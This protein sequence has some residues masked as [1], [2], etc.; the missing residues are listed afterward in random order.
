LNIFFL[1]HLKSLQLLDVHIIE[2][3]KKDVLY[4]HMCLRQ[5][6]SRVI[7]SL[8]IPVSVHSNYFS[9]Q[10]LNYSL[11]SVF[12]GF[13]FQA[14]VYNIIIILFGRMLPFF[15]N[16][17]F[18]G[19]IYIYSIATILLLLYEYDDADIMNTIRTI[20]VTN[21]NIV[22]NI[23]QLRIGQKIN[24]GLIEKVALGWSFRT[25][26]TCFCKYIL[27]YNEAQFFLTLFCT[28]FVCFWTTVHVSYMNLQL[29]LPVLICGSRRIILI[30]YKGNRGNSLL[31]GQ[32]WFAISPNRPRVWNCKCL[33]LLLY[34]TY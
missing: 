25:V 1:K 5:L 18:F 20:T 33:L 3:N 6:L 16:N 27:Y 23:V 13:R 26:L 30:Y 9:L 31:I 15:L 4:V 8:S 2:V 28:D 34:S 29:S 22:N 12:S 21:K 10:I 7:T 11:V 17:I 24:K 14:S 19:C 32:N